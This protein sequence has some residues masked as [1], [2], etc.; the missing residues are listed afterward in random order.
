MAKFER[1]NKI[2]VHFRNYKTLPEQLPEFFALAQ[3]ESWL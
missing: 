1:T 2:I 3:L